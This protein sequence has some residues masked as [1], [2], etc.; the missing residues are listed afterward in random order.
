[1]SLFRVSEGQYLV[2]SPC[3][4]LVHAYE[5]GCHWPLVGQCIASPAEV[6]APGSLVRQDGGF[7]HERKPAGAD[8]ILC[9]AGCR[10]YSRDALADK[11]PVAPESDDTVIIM[12]RP[13]QRWQGTSDRPE[14]FWLRR[15]RLSSTVAVSRRVAGPVQRSDASC[16]RRRAPQSRA[17]PPSCFFPDRRGAG[18]RRRPRPSGSRGRTR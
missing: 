9:E 11:R 7:L 5:H 10:V 15:H 13:A 6:A 8:N 1:M 16:L 4:T 14:R 18:F 3:A 17:G 12:G 2:M